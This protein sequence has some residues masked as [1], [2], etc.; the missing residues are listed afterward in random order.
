VDCPPGRGQVKCSAAG[1]HAFTV[2]KNSCDVFNSV[3]RREVNDGLNVSERGVR[4]TYRHSSLKD[5]RTLPCRIYAVI[6]WRGYDDISHY[7]E[8]SLTTSQTKEDP[9]LLASESGVVLIVGARPGCVLTGSG[10]G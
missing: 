7:F 5:R 9:P 6:H 3:G 10:L 1:V 4:M 2:A 8:A